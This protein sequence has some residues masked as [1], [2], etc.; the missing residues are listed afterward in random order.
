[1]VLLP[2]DLLK[3]RLE[4]EGAPWRSVVLFGKGGGG[5]WSGVFGRLSFATKQVL[6]PPPRSGFCLVLLFAVVLSCSVLWDA[7]DGVRVVG[8]TAMISCR[9]V[10]A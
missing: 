2:A 3:R 1:M 5:G 8:W 6:G 7:V 9:G 10:T 4:R